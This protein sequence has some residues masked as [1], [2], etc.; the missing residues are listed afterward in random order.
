MVTYIGI[1]PRRNNCP[2]KMGDN[3][4]WLVAPGPLRCVGP[5]RAHQTALCIHPQHAG[6]NTCQPIVFKCSG[7]CTCRMPPLI[8][9]HTYGQPL[10]WLILV[11]LVTTAQWPHISYIY[12]GS[13]ARGRVGTTVSTNRLCDEAVASVRDL[14]KRARSTGTLKRVPQCGMRKTVQST[15]APSA[16][17]ETGM[18]RS[19]DEVAC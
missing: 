15:I 4:G 8:R 3:D 18:L 17:Y 13:R 6:I 10:T 14:G 2:T 1:R 7:A 5:R 19:S 12:L 16:M 11:G 9:Q